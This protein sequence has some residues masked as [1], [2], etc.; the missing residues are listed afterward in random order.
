[1][2]VE[3]IIIIFFLSIQSQYS[4]NFFQYCIQPTCAGA[5]IAEGMH[6]SSID[7]PHTKFQPITNADNQE[8]KPTKPLIRQDNKVKILPTQEHWSLMADCRS[9]PAS[10]LIPAA[11]PTEAGPT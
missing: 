1:M 2:Q 5:Y 3:Y 9:W 7:N 10:G 11:V 6:L 4:A 8:R